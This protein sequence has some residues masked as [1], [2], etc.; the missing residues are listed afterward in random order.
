MEIHNNKNENNTYASNLIEL[1]R[2][3]G[4]DVN[5]YALWV[6]SIII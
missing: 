3:K 5:E 1:E 6:Y 2:I 4:D